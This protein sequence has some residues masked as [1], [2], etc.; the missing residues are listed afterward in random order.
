MTSFEVYCP[1]GH[2]TR[3]TA[4]QSHQTVNCPTCNT[5]I[6]V[7][8]LSTAQRT[9]P[10][11]L[12]GRVP[13]K[14]EGWRA[15]WEWLMVKEEPKVRA[16]RV[17]GAAL[18]LVLL[19]IFLVSR[20]SNS[21]PTP[22]GFD[23]GSASSQKYA[24]AIEEV[25]Q[26]DRENSQRMQSRHSDKAAVQEYVQA[27]DRIDLRACPPEFQQAF[28]KHKD[29]WSATLP[30]IEKYEGFSGGLLALLEGMS[31][32]EDSVKEVDGRIRET[33]REC[34]LI[35]LRHGVKISN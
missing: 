19:L 10:A 29:A 34:Q 15:I 9:L 14:S 21:H 27:F 33:W 17:G 7:P 3:V 22:K 4:A 23:S 35:A 20:C 2:A 24:A 31:K 1:L 13:A 18:L 6:T 28:L 11:P 26:K 16:W 30:I 25:L 32:V 5:P 12:P 8:D